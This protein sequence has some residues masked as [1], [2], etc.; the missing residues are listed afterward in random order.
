[1]L[2]NTNQ[3]GLKYDHMRKH[4]GETMKEYKPEKLIT[5]SRYRNYIPNL[6]EDIKREMDGSAAIAYR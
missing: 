3:G 5:I 4:V 6:S 1:M 2:A